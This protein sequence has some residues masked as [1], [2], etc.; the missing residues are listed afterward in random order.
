M[1]LKIKDAKISA[2]L[3]TTGL[4][5]IMIGCWIPDDMLTEKLFQLKIALIIIG[6]VLALAVVFWGKFHFRCPHCGDAYIPPLWKA[7]RF[8]SF[9]GQ[10]IEWE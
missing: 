6:T 9:C 2:A 4:L 8:C 1:K 7:E 10:K 5:I 3:L